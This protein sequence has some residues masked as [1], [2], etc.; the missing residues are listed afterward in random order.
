MHCSVLS[1]VFADG[2]LL[3]CR[4]SPWRGCG[5]EPPWFHPVQKSLVN[6]AG[7]SIWRQPDRL[8][9]LKTE[10][11]VRLSESPGGVVAHHTTLSR[12]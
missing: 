10:T 5:L 4:V 3:S 1:A 6:T 9:S 7:S 8:E 12:S 2:R 11:G